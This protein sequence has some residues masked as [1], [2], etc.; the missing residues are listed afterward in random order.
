[1]PFVYNYR[2][3]LLFPW[4]L[5]SSSSQ[6]ALKEKIR[7]EEPYI[8][9]PSDL[10]LQCIFEKEPRREETLKIDELSHALHNEFSTTPVGGKW[11]LLVCRPAAAAAWPQQSPPALRPSCRAG[12]P[13]AADTCPAAWR[14]PLQ[15][16]AGSVSTQN[17]P[18]R[19][20]RLRGRILAWEQALNSTIA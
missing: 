8:F 3:A 7:G 12:W 19:K 17:Y 5:S 15:R 14:A 16:T 11:A 9:L 13:P 6:N 4:F 20:T 2:R 18:E 1:M 10:L